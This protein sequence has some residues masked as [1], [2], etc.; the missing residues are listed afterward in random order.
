MSE[1]ENPAPG[2]GVDRNETGGQPEETGPTVQ[3]EISSM[4]LFL[5]FERTG[6]VLLC[7]GRP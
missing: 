4:Y 2:A 6:R 5:G 3:L 1:N 7:V